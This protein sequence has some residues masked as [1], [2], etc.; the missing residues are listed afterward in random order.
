[1]ARVLIVDDNRFFRE[2]L[3]KRFDCEP[4]FEVCGEAENGKE[5]VEQAL[6]LHPDLIVLDL[7]MPVMNGIDAARVLRLLMPTLP[8]I[9]NTAFEDE[10]VEQQAHLIGVSE[11]VPKSAQAL[12]QA[13]RRIQYLEQM[14]A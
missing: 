6:K 4:E 8:L 14:A 1:M 7:L 12:I 3:S 13:A 10:L 5:A 11:I 9:M 2:L